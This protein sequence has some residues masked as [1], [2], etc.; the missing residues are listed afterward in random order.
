MQILIGLL[1]GLMGTVVGGAVTW[2]TTDRTLR[3][4]LEQSYDKE[5]RTARIAAYK[6]LWQITS[7]LPRYA[8]PVN[9]TR[10]ELRALIEEFHSWYF[11]VGGLFLSQK[12]KD[13]YFDMMNAL[14]D[15]AG[16][17][18]VDDTRVDSSTYEQLF[19]YGESLRIELGADIGT[20]LQSRV[21][22]TKLRRA[23]VPHEPIT[24]LA[25][26]SLALPISPQQRPPQPDS[27]PAIDPD[28]ASEQ[29]SQSGT[30]PG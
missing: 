13:A 12:S 20:G 16:R 28:R 18:I 29:Q 9:P 25:S 4:K 21:P 2:F 15:A 24:D 1:G 23:K 5:L 30:R 26:S 3:R 27:E 17:R 22:S 10:S 14:D 6:Q 7:S 11:A 8:W 19:E